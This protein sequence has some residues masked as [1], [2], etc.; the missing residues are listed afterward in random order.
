MG[1]KSVVYAKIADLRARLDDEEM[2]LGPPASPLY[3]ELLIGVARRKLGAKLPPEYLSFLQDFDGLRA[4]G[5]FIY[6]SR[7]LSKGGEE[8]IGHGFIWNNLFRRQLE[9]MEKFL[10]FGESDMDEYVLDLVR[11]KYQVR[12]RVAFDNV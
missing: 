9:G 5:V 7:L 6:S 1:L 4:C 8:V 2:Y 11:G 12:D 10:V 3:I